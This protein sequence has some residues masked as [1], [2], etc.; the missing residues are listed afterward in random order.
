MA[1]SSSPTPPVIFPSPPICPHV[2]ITTYT[3]VEVEEDDDEYDTHDDH[4]DDVDGVYDDVET[5]TK[6][7][8]DAVQSQTTDA[9]STFE[10]I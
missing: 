2:I 5:D 7:E 1:S 8:L 6:P 9:L 10:A 3:I 4:F